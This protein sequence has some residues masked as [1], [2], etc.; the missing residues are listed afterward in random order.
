MDPKHTPPLKLEAYQTMTTIPEGG[1]AAQALQC[2]P[3]TEPSGWGL[4]VSSLDLT[5]TPERPKL[6]AADF[7]ADDDD[8]YIAARA[9]E[10]GLD[11]WQTAR[12]IRQAL[13][14]RTALLDMA[15][16]GAN[17][18]VLATPRPTPARTDGLSFPPGFAGELASFVYQQAPR[19]VAEVAIVAALGLLAGICGRQWCTESGSGLNI[20]AILVARSGIGKEALHL[21][22]EKLTRAASRKCPFAGNYVSFDD[23]VSGPALVKTIIKNPCFVNV[24]GEVGHKFKAMASVKDGPMQTFRK[25]LLELYSKSGPASRTGGLVYSNSD[26]NVDSAVGA[27]FSLIGET[28]PGTFFGCLTGDMMEDGFMSRFNVIEY[29]GDRPEPNP[30]PLKEPGPA[31]TDRLVAII[32]HAETLKGRDLHVE[33]GQDG[34][35]RTLLK[36]FEEEADAEIVGV[37]NEAW[38][39]MFNRA[40]LKALRIAS[41]LAVADRYLEPV[42]K[43]DYAKWAID[44]VR[45]DIAIFQRRLG[46]GDI[47]S[48]NDYDREAKLVEICREY[49]K[50]TNKTMP[51]FV[52]KW[53]H[54]QEKGVVSRAYLSNKVQKARAFES[55]PRGPTEA[56]NLALRSAVD[57]GWLMPVS[58][59][60]ASTEFGVN[61]LLYRIMRLDDHRAR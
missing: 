28:T 56:L 34:A 25:K 57:D 26:Q 61:G 46:N 38:R 23:I 31:V 35:A 32:E 59:V 50:L 8:W 19:P 33:V 47:G 1:E 30:D 18:P 14:Q 43:Y 13:T 55:H 42:V 39:Q 17:V 58:K 44:L 15:S 22:I 45:A 49:V 48:G 52:Q 36:S 12:E 60:A 4:D 3:H 7:D 20:Y 2:S 21:G 51:A 16:E 27:A 10:L 11:P 54:L 41:L 24:A 40:H 37:E 9:H 6:K 29:T 53:A 5:P